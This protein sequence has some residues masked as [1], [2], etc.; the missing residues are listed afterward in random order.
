MIKYI[1]WFAMVPALL[2]ANVAAAQQYP[3]LD[4]VANRIV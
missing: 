4:A 1:L 3:M 2:F